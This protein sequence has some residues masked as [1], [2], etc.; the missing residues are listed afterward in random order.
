[1]NNI[2]QHYIIDL[3]SN[4]NFVQVPTVQGDGN[5]IRGFE[6]EL[7]QNGL[8]YIVDR[9]DTMIS[10]MGTKP[11]T[12]QVMNDCRLS[13]DGF[14]HVDI[15]S[16]MSAVKGRGEY[17][18]VLFS[19]SANSQLKSF[20]FYIITTSAAFD[21]DQVASSDEFQTLTKNITQ[22]ETLIKKA[23]AAISDLNRFESVA[24]DAESRRVAAENSRITEEEKRASAEASR[25]RKENERISNENGR[26]AA[27]AIREN[28]ENNRAN[29]E[30]IRNSS[31]NERRTSEDVRI[32]SET[33][34]ESQERTRN[35]NETGRENAERERSKTEM[36]RIAAEDARVSSEA[37]RSHAEATRL[38]SEAARQH[39]ES[40]RQ[41]SSTAAVSKADKAASRANAAAKLCENIASDLSP[42]HEV[43]S[44]TEPSAGLQMA[45]DFWLQ[46]YET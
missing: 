9:D 34:R 37:E 43:I 19:K 1:M 42:N 40:Q 5:N 22:T 45:G 25:V 16:Q 4:N 36:A 10:I 20:P 21:M 28:T 35:E 46:E 12:S 39:N 2:Y 31:E 44:P 41:S 18:I 3:S 29:A 32:A 6:V 26:K 17:Q 11:D 33:L 13:D 24:A 15:T 38:E 27:E 23:N 14:I 7:I 30:I 8:P